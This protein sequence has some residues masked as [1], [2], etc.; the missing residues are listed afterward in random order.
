MQKTVNI[1][2]NG[3]I[4]TVVVDEGTNL[5][6]FLRSNGIAMETPCGG[7]GTCGK[8]AVRVSGIKNTPSERERKLLG[9]E[10]LE[11][12]YRLSCSNNITSDLDIYPEADSAREASI[13]TEGK[14][15]DVE[16]NPIIRKQYAELAVPAL[17][18]QTPD[19]ERVLAA[20]EVQLTD[21][22]LPLL[23]TISSIL[24]KSDYK[25]TLVSMNEK[26]LAVEA[27]DTTRKL[28]GTAFDIG[29]TTVAAYLYDMNTG[30]CLAV[31][32]MLNPQKK[33]GADVIARI[34]HTMQADGGKEEMYSSIIQC[35]NDLIGQLCQKAGLSRSDIYCAVFTGN[36]TMLHFLM[37][38]DASA[39]SVS[40]FIPVTTS[41]QYFDGLSAGIEMNECGQAVVFPGVSAYVG[42]DTVAA[43]LSSGMYDKE[44]ISLLVDIGTNGEI[45]LGGKEW[46]LSCSTAAGPAFE[47]ANI[48]NGV[49]GIRGAIDTVGSGPDFSYTTLGNA[50]PVGI[51]GSGIIDAIAN[52]IDAGLIEDT[53]RLVDSDEAEEIDPSYKDRLI[54]IDGVKAFVLANESESGS[55]SQ[56]VITQKD[57]REL[58][59]AKA[60]IAAGIET[61]VKK[62][63]K[64]F[65]EVKKVYLAGGFGSRINIKSALKVGLLPRTL[66]NRIEAIGNASGAGAAEGLLSKEMLRL[67]EKLKLNVKYIELSASPD[68][69]EKYVDNMMFE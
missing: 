68:F 62:S 29:T 43:I 36:T 4:K 26:L 7:K 1:H 47:G 60:A 34:S 52:L 3:E 38:L 22:S 19:I 10:K 45:V 16:I 25:V 49:G 6:M 17:A 12:G 11:K 69:V 24:R 51:C 61:L 21:V 5:L 15:R 31:S 53:G 48:K 64:D 13:I 39:I 46:L 30:K 56:I 59:N 55:G 9:A 66:E 40:P 54:S 14:N 41:L 37:G 20:S 58:Q 27:G 18:D 67:S 50:S 33:F 35:I 44:E 23:R 57:I 42:G 2:K 28:C 32:S 8:C 63:G 65:D